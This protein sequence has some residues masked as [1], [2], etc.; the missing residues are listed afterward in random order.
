MRELAGRAF[1]ELKIA[2][3][4]ILRIHLS[5]I[6]GISSVQVESRLEP[7]AVVALIAKLIGAREVFEFG[8]YKG[9]TTMLIAQNCPECRIVTIDLPEGTS[10][11]T[12]RATARVEMTDAYLFDTGARGQFISGEAANRITQIR[13]DSG[14]FDEGPYLGRFDLVYVDASHSYSAVK[15]DTQKALRMLRPG[16]IIMWD[17]YDYPGVWQYL[18]E[19]ARERPHF[20]LRYV[21]DWGK[22]ILLGDR[23]RL[24]PIT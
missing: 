22:V 15:S 23:V 21:S 3:S 18:N 24:R 16:G 6:E 17:D 12:A 14:A 5:D 9:A 10:Y 8:T 11:E 20:E 1:R 19:L 2:A 7:G 13:Q 4:P